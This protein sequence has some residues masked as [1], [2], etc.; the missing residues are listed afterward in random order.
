[1]RWLAKPLADRSEKRDVTRFAFI[2]VYVDDDTRFVWLERYSVYQE[3]AHRG[4]GMGWV[5][6]AKYS[7]GAF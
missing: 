3:W 1:M 7:L 4:Y 2:P 5:T 6:V